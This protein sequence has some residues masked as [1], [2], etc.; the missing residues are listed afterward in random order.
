MSAIAKRRIQSLHPWLNLQKIQN[1]LHHDRDVHPRR[2]PALSDDLLDRIAVLFRV[3]L[4]VL[5]LI[6]PRMR[7]GIADTA[8]VRGLIRIIIYFC[9]GE[10]PV[11]FFVFLYYY[12]F[13]ILSS[14]K[15]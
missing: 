2:S 13:H 14:G 15:R 4:L 10:P 8:L 5:F 9:H 11:W 1:F 6:R 7:T 3:Q 12:K